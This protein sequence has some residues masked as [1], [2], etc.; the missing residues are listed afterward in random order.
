[1][2]RG[3]SQAD[4]RQGGRRSCGTMKESWRR[5]RGCTSRVGISAG[6]RDATCRSTGPIHPSRQRCPTMVAAAPTGSRSGR[7]IFP[8][9]S[10]SPQRVIHRCR[11]PRTGRPVRYCRGPCNGTRPASRRATRNRR[12]THA[13]ADA[14]CGN[15]PTGSPRATSIHR[16]PLSDALAIVLA[17][18][19]GQPL[20]LADRVL[21][22]YLLTLQPIYP[23]QTLAWLA[24]QVDG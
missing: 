17:Q 18:N 4:L 19:S 10:T 5:L 14:T 22:D 24:D 13:C 6:T 3:Q 21:Y 8:R 23:A 9:V 11:H 1:M 2:R 16:V 12:I 20:L 15:P 7:G